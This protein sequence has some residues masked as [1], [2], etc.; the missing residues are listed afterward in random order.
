MALACELTSLRADAIV[1]TAGER[2][3]RIGDQGCGDS[4]LVDGGGRDQ[5]GWYAQLVTRPGPVSGRFH[6]SPP[7]PGRWGQ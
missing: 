1:V 4:P 7:I 2:I 3:L 5:I 6:L